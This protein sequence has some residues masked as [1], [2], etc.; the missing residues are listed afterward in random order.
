MPL[1]G[2]LVALAGR[3]PTIAQALADRRTVL[4]LLCST[5]IL[6]VN[7][8]IYILA[9]NSERILESSL[10]YY[11]NPLVMVV[12]G[13]V[14]LKERLSP[15]QGIAVALAALGVANMVMQLGTLPWIAL[16]LAG[17]FGT[18]GLIRKLVRLGSIEGLFVETSLML[19][20]A[21]CYAG[22]LAYSGN[23]YFLARDWQLDILIV[24]AGPVTSLPLVW[25]ASGARRLNYATVGI[26][27]FIAPS[28]H[29]LLGV[30]VYDE[31]FGRAHLITFACIWVAIVIFSLDSLRS[32]RREAKQLSA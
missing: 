19:P 13:M 29:F 26:F 10:G 14:F 3:G 22:F 21:L 6:S 15:W 30:F 27:Q 17:T 1:L 25:F 32:L 7:W 18:Y 12:L 9:I 16:A 4:A 8:F 23:A 24:L 11:I 5:L 20:V 31:P 28:G 2:L